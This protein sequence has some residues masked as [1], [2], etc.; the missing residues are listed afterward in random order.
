MT[1]VLMPRL[2]E[3]MED[4][5]IVAWLKSSGAAVSAGEDIAEIEADKV[6]T[7]LQALA[8]GVLETMAA[9][10]PAIPVGQVIARI[11]PGAGTDER[12]LPAAP[13]REESRDAVAQTVVVADADPGPRELPRDGVLATPQ[14]R[15]LART[16]GVDLR[17]VAGSAP[18]GRVLR[19]DVEAAAQQQPVRPSVVELSPLQRVIARRMTEAH[20][21]IP[22]FQIQTE[23]CA[24]AAFVLREQLKDAG[25]ATVP[26]FTDIIVKVCGVAL[27]EHPRANGSYAAD[28]FDLHDRVNVGFAVAGENLLLVP[29]VTDADTRSLGDISRE[30]RRLAERARAG[31]ITADELSGA[32]FTVSNLGMY[33]MTAIYPV[34]N[35]PQAAILGV[36]SVRT[37]PAI[38]DGTFVERR[39]LTLTLSCDHRI[40][41]GAD[42]AAF[43]VRIRD[44]LEQPVSLLLD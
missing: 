40:L 11:R 7:T 20:A 35:P 18:R 31:T 3:T 12:D 6:S 14:A 21:T 8:D 13:A 4:G 44:L 34:I 42:A 30:T 23:A 32:T 19:S 25:A 9:E 2:S 24:D 27:R 26:S 28:R 39:M 16:F 15:R 38:D 41:Y 43:L 22:D 5:T 10:G 29:T 36:G 33:G 17:S 37:V 1:D